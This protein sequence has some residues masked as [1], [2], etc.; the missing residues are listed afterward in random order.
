MSLLH[1]P[2]LDEIA[3]YMRSEMNNELENQKACADVRKRAAIAAAT[4][5]MVE[6]V[7]GV[8]RAVSKLSANGWSM[9]TNLS[10]GKDM[11]A[12]IKFTK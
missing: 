10:A 9:L 5:D 4:E 12:G 8:D 2:V 6:S 7:N 1:I 3:D 11:F